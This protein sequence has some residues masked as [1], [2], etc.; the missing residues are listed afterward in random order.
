MKHLKYI[1]PVLIFMMLSV[2]VTQA[3]TNADLNRLLAEGHRAISG[4]QTEEAAR[5]AAEIENKYSG[6]AL[7]HYYLAR[8]QFENGDYVK[9]LEHL[10]AAGGEIPEEKG[11]AGF[12]PYLRAAYENT[13]DF[14]SRKSPHF[15]IRYQPGKEEIILDYAIETLEKAYMEM[16]T[17]FA[18]S[19]SGL[20]PVEI[21]P[22]L[23]MLARATGLSMEA[24]KTT[25]TIGIC[26]FNRLLVS[27]P[28]V[29]LMGYS[30]RDTMSHELV[31]L[32]V[33]KVGNNKVPVW[34]HEGL[35]KFEEL[36]WRR[37]PGGELKLSYESLL[38]RALRENKLVTLEEMHPSMALLPSQEHG[39]L[40][41]AEVLTIVQF[42]YMQKGFPGLRQLLA[43][44]GRDGDLD[45]A[46]KTVYGFDTKS[47][48]EQWKRNMQ[49]RG[50]RETPETWADYKL[51]FD[52]DEE[53]YEKSEEIKLNRKRA[54]NY[55]VLGKLLK[56]RQ[57]SAAAITEYE[58]ATSIEGQGNVILQNRL[59]Q[60][61]LD[62]KQPRKALEA[63]NQ[64]VDLYPGY[65]GTHIRRAAAYLAQGEANLALPSLIE[66]VGI[67]PFDPR[68]WQMMI[69]A[70]EATSRKDKAAEAE[71]AMQLLAT[72]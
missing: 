71:R 20:I 43:E 9:A 72:H 23:S 28:R 36:R 8:F 5:V 51:I 15:E 62:E 65:V 68:V 41:Y 38:S 2:A 52:Q 33:S 49:S 53:S 31:H 29:S 39:A 69:E 54:R 40:A 27:S 47:L 44:I 3:A 4:W 50:L 14:K 7:A 6:E 30:W 60:A 42:L 10:E 59:A 24:L 67:N 16:A 56:D 34:L 19:P 18:Y 70:Y 35:A 48:Q 22:D 58:K 12:E 63:L 32:F 17:D 26:K 11:G 57:H 64:V 21:Y 25:G 66:A 13:K 46:F 37:Q 61:Y 55:M 45:R 1:L